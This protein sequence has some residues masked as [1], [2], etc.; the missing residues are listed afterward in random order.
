[1]EFISAI[2]IFAISTSVTPGPNTIM[3]MSSGLNYGVKSSMPHLLGICFGF[4][5]MVVLVG[6]GLGFIFERYGFIHEVIKLVGIVYLVYLAWVIGHS[7]PVRLDAKQ[8]APISFMQA[9]LFQWV[10]PKAW[11]TA[12]SAI[13]AYT[14]TASDIYLQVTVIAAVFF[15]VAFPCVGIWIVFGTKLQRLLH[16]PDQQKLFNIAMALLLLVSVI[17]AIYELGLKY[18]T[19]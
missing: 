1:M 6:L 17:P 2:F 7:S 18:L 15:L 19:D 5:A 11:V 16:K 10:N 8:S 14:S 3:M 4:P 9:A 13:A 12:T